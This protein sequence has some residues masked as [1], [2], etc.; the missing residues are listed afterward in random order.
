MRILC[1]GSSVID[2]FIKIEDS[3][4]IETI[5]NKIALS[6]GDKIPVNIEK[7]ALGGNAANVA[8]GLKRLSQQ[9]ILFTYLGND[10]F[11]RE[12]E[13]G[14]KKEGIKILTEANPEQ[15]SSLS[16]IFE[17]NKDRVIFSHHDRR[18]YSFSFA[19]K[20]LP[21][22]VYLTSIGK[23]W[24]NAYGQVLEFARSNNISLCFSPGSN[25]LEEKNGIFF[26]VLKNSQMLFVNK[27]EAIKI[28]QWQ[29]IE[30]GKD[31]KSLLSSLKYLGPMIV[32]VT[33][34][35]NG[36]CVIDKNDI[37]Y[38]IAAFGKNSEFVERTGAGDAYASGFLAKYFFDGKVDEAV[39][40]GCL[41]AYSGMQK[42][43]AQEGLLN[44]NQMELL[45][46]RNTNYKA[47]R[48]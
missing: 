9:T 21:D 27:D 44:T 19:E 18:D 22:F 8:V 15:K 6:L 20:T 48:F 29:N 2:L 11:S 17:M 13:E 47:E 39:V 23:E 40:W 26:E 14:I 34:G 3:S 12:I 25:Q 4:C 16:F 28:L 32:S 42:M 5:N 37:Y 36:A 38:K 31:I 7:I 45:I 30:T 33:D 1:V 35:E 10:L 24:T 46:S 41:N 43:G